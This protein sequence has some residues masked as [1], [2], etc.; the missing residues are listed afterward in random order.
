MDLIT[1]A[2]L[3]LVGAI[4]AWALQWFF[5]DIP[6]RARL[7]RQFEQDL[8]ASRNETEKL[9]VELRDS[10]VLLTCVHPGGVKTN[11]VRNARIGDLSR[12]ADNALDYANDFEAIAGSTPE[13]AAAA[14]VGAI[15]SRKPRLLIGAD[16]RLMDILYRLWPTR[17][18]F[19]L[20]NLNQL[21]RRWLQKRRARLANATR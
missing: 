3:V 15:Q 19:W 2:L 14:I 11:I 1:I 20:D 8:T 6:T 7:T 13:Q 16:A 18:A 5:W 10:N 12:V 4:I 21:A 9:R 17:V